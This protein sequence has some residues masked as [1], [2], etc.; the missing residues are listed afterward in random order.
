YPAGA[1][2]GGVQEGDEVYFGASAFV[3]QFLSTSAAAGGSPDGGVT[4]GAGDKGAFD[5]RFEIA[6]PANISMVIRTDI[7]D[8]HSGYCVV[9]RW[10]SQDTENYHTYVLTPNEGVQ[11]LGEGADA[12]AVNNCP[13]FDGQGFTVANHPG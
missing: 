4:P 12:E 7:P 5:D 6:M 1:A 13:V 3:T 11:V 8:A 10:N 2:T 9:A